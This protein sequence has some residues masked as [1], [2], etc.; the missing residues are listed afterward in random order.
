MSSLWYRCLVFYICDAGYVIANSIARWT[1]GLGKADRGQSLLFHEFIQSWVGYELVKILVVF[2]L[3]PTR[4]THRYQKHEKTYNPASTFTWIMS[5]MLDKNVGCKFFEEMNQDL[6]HQVNLTTEEISTV[7]N[8]EKP[9][10]S[11]SRNDED[12]PPKKNQNQVFYLCTKLIKKTVAM[13][14]KIL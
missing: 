10:D 12:P 5:N 4:W 2:R 6:L 1:F 13:T 9:S 3:Q 7:E 8:K 11:N 14:V